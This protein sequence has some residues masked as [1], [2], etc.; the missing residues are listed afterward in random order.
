MPFEREEISKGG[1]HERIVVDRKDAGDGQEDLRV[2][3]MVDG[4]GFEFGNGTLPRKSQVSAAA[5]VQRQ[6]WGAQA[7]ASTIH[8]PEYHSARA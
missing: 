3:R 6:H 7:P 5:K 1:T 8:S 2:E 4:A